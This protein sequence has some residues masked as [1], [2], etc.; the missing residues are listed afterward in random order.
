MRQ[1]RVEQVKQ[2]SFLTGPMQ[3]KK[4]AELLNAASKEGWTFSHVVKSETRWLRRDTFMV[5]FHRDR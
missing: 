1:Y 2:S 4:F 5:V 3:A